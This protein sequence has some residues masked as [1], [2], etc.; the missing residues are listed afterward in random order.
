MGSE[1]KN[2]YTN[3]FSRLGNKPH[4]VSDNDLD[5]MERFVV[6]LYILSVQNTSSCAL[7]TVRLENFVC[8][9]DNDLRKLPPSWEALCKQAKHSFFQSAYLWVKAV[10]DILLPEASLWGWIFNENKGVFVSLW[11]SGTCSITIEKFTYAC[12]CYKRN[13]KTCKWERIG[14]IPMCGCKKKCGSK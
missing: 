8:S 5:I 9:S 13:C 7:A 10:Q 4:S 14:C 2:I 6:E 1:H 11:Q 3:L 12:S